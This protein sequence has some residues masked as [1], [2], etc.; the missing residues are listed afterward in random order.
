MA[1]I[2]I[3]GIGY[4][5][6]PDFAAQPA[7]VEAPVPAAPKASMV[8]AAQ[9]AQQQLAAQQ[10]QSAAIPQAPATPAATFAVNPASGFDANAY[11]TQNP[12]IGEYAA[13]HNLDPTA[14]AAEHYN[15]T[16]QYEIAAG[17]RQAG[18]AVTPTPSTT[19][20]TATTLTPA[21]A[22]AQ[23]AA[24]GQVPDVASIAALIKS[25][26][27][28]DAARVT[29]PAVAPWDSFAVTP[30]T[31]L[32]P[33]VNTGQPGSTFD[34]RTY[35]AAN[36]YQYDEATGKVVVPSSVQ[37]K[38]I[39]G[40]TP[41]VA[42]AAAPAF[43]VQAFREQN[44]DLDA[45]ANAH[46]YDPTQFAIDYYNLTGKDEI[47]KGQRY[48]S[49][50]T[51]VKPPQPKDVTP[52]ATWADYYTKVPGAQDWAI[53]AMQAEFAPSGWA[54]GPIDSMEEAAAYQQQAFGDQGSGIKF[55]AKDPGKY[56]YDLEHPDLNARGM[57]DAN[58]QIQIVDANKLSNPAVKA[59]DAKAQAAVDKV[60][61]GA[62]AQPDWAAYTNAYPDLVAAAKAQGV[63]A[64]TF[65][66]EHYLDSGRAEGRTV[67]GL[68]AGAAPP[69]ATGT[70]INPNA[71]TLAQ[72]AGM[73][74]LHKAGTSVTLDSGKVL[75]PGTDYYVTY[76]NDGD[77]SGVIG[78]N[79]GQKVALIDP[80]TEEILFYGV[81]PEAAAQAAAMANQISSD[82]G[83]KAAWQLAINTSESDDEKNWQV[84]AYDKKDPK[85]NILG[86]I[87]SIAL[88]IL[89]AIVLPGIGA[90]L[91]I[92]GLV[93]SSGAATALGAGLGAGI[94]SLAASGLNGDSF[95]SALLKAG[96]TGLTAGLL[97][98]V[99]GMDKLGS[100]LGRIPGLNSGLGALQGV[101]NS[102]GS[103]LGGA[104]GTGAAS[105]TAGALASTT[106]SLIGGSS[107]G[108]L[109]GNI[110]SDMLAGGIS[111]SI[112]GTTAASAAAA[113]TAASTM[114]GEV[115]VTAAT[116]NAVVQ[117]AMS[118]LTGAALT[119]VALD[120]MGAV[121]GI[122]VTAAKK[123]LAIKAAGGI[124]VEEL[125]VTAPKKVDDLT[126]NKDTAAALG[127]GIA[128]TAAPSLTDRL[129]SNIKKNPLGAA[130]AALSIAGA[131]G[132]GGGSKNGQYSS[133]F[134]GGT[135]PGTR[136]SLGSVFTDSSM[137]AATFGGRTGTGFAADERYG[138]GPEA[139]FFTNTAGGGNNFGVMS[140]GNGFGDIS[141]F[142]ASSTGNA[143]LANALAP[144]GFDASSDNF[145]TWIAS[146]PE[147]V[148]AQVRAI[149]ENN[150]QVA[151][152]K[153]GGFAVRGDGSG[154]EDKIPA[155][156][157]DG[158]YVIDAETVAMLGDGSGAHG[159]KKL[160]QF[161]VNVRKHK[162]KQMARG[163]FSANAKAPEQYMRGAA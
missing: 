85:N 124:P 24:S 147:T 3:E 39:P 117:A 46:G 31:T 152:F 86:K 62:T 54:G 144:L 106:G 143:A 88:P 66:K 110:A 97:P 80:K 161:R 77:V 36:G 104:L 103:S 10:Q 60:A 149:F 22:A 99:P 89:G 159:A 61:P 92:G 4:I 107:T 56:Y 1:Q 120:N 126:L 122:D 136:G 78:A 91:G 71:A 87:A 63:D 146:Q 119:S 74:D 41:G 155:V 148:K 23:I 2:Y 58:G 52:G 158:E 59:F 93:G 130:A 142:A 43:D 153:K 26:S 37:A 128:A 154:R 38:Q 156:L 81:G 162:G 112:I 33:S 163:R 49:A 111:S 79:A 40:G 118:G 115:V 65:G 140:G 137:P 57:L 64:A 139:R 47:A 11:L 76:T 30:D 70:Y 132:A 101:G 138:F 133:S 51:Q 5:D 73:A 68:A 100:A 141:P 135:K 69:A 83:R 6:I 95:K 53:K 151:T 160:D 134:T 42:A 102:I 15:T 123:Q 29:D 44:P 98:S 157:S 32:G 96:L 105:S 131:L 20:A 16:G 35:A 45:W 94:G 17:G 90:G 55:A 14:F 12:D 108:S 67:P 25:M 8:D 13:A 125:V 50:D 19:G 129:T 150:G 21:A 109:M 28:N 18:F 121:Q 84:A 48:L 82:K 27:A 113:L 127:A 75:T 7:A 116:K 34:A 114:L 145:D 72:S 9:L